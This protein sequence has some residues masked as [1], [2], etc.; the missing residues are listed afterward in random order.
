M[1]MIENQV[2][3]FLE[4]VDRTLKV[5]HIWYVISGMNLY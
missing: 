4:E 1:M 3:K 5:Y 2:L